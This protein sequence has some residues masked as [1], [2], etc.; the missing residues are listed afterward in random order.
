MPADRGS[1]SSRPCPSPSQPPTP[2]LNHPPPTS[3]LLQSPPP[4]CHPPQDPGYHAKLRELTRQTGTLLIIDE[5]H[6]ICAGPGGYSA[7]A[8]L[9][10][11]IFVIGKVGFGA[12]GCGVVGQVRFAFGC[13]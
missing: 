3:S 10:P 7:V 1:F 9:D 8:G 6:S 2:A 12:V 13:G 5:T 4:S 11:D